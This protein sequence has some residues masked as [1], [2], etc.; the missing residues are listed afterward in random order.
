MVVVKEPSLAKFIYRTHSIPT[1]LLIF[2]LLN[3]S[4]LWLLFF[5]VYTVLRKKIFSFGIVYK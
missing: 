5:L 2:F 1:I 4:H 3:Y